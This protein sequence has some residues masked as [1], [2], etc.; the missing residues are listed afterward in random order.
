MTQDRAPD[1]GL[2]PLPQVFHDWWRSGSEF[3]EDLEQIM[4][5]YAQAT[6][7]A[8]RERI[9]ELRVEVRDWQIEANRQR[10][11][12]ERAEQDQQSYRWLR[13]HLVGPVPV[14]RV[15]IME[16]GR[17]ILRETPTELDRAIA[18]AASAQEGGK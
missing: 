3:K 1:E 5:S 8:E 7:Q 18:N 17:Y 13:S 15:Q 10:E 9:D 11:R 12:A 14:V 6:L 16:R 4:R 2:P